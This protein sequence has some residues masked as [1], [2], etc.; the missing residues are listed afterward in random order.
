MPD[1]VEITAVPIYKNS[2]NEIPV[3]LGMDVSGEVLTSQIRAGKTQDSELIATFTVSMDDSEDAEGDGSDG[4][5]VLTL[6][7]S[8]LTDVDH[9]KGYM[10]V[11]RMS[12]GEPIPAFS[13]PLR[14]NFE[15]TVTA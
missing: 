12:A 14:V 10:D 15:D 13:P 6:D 7:D 5:I 8:Q 9:K 2:Y 3:D 1:E 11:K 4:K